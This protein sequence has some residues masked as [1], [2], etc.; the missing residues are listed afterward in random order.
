MHLVGGL[1][2]VCFPLDIC[3]PSQEAMYCHL[4]NYGGAFSLLVLGPV[5]IKDSR[6]GND[7]MCVSESS[8]NVRLI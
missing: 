4:D 8:F 7:S 2:F 3:A 6:V 1:D 5:C